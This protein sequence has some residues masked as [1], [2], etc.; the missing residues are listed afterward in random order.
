MAI[1]SLQEVLAEAYSATQA[2]GQ[3]GQKHTPP[4][5]REYHCPSSL[6]HPP[7]P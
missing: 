1:L 7:P 4:P 3:V 6:A 5:V 2:L